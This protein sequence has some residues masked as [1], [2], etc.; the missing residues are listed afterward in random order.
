MVE[1]GPNNIADEENDRH[2]DAAPEATTPVNKSSYKTM[3]P[4]VKKFL[5]FQSPAHSF[6]FKLWKQQNLS[7]HMA[8]AMLLFIGVPNMAT[9]FNWQWIG[10]GTETTAQF[11]GQLSLVPLNVLFVVY[12]G[13]LVILN[14][15]PVQV[16]PDAPPPSQLQGWAVWALTKTNIE[17]LICY[18]CI[19]ANTSIFIGRVMHGACTEP[20]A[21]NIWLTQQCNPVANRS[22]GL[23]FCIF[24]VMPVLGCVEITRFCPAATLSRTTRC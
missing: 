24:S 12:I 7:L 22:A 14:Y 20:E 23:Y 19:V 21:A 8:I 18:G 9:R 11:V 16:G 6:E 1:P 13:S 3:Y 15:H 4:N 2:R 17:D 10:L 5:F